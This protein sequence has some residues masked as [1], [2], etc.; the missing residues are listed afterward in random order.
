MKAMT[1]FISIALVTMAFGLVLAAC[2]GDDPTPT[3]PPTP[4]TAAP[5][6]AAPTT[7]AEATATPT[8]APTF[9]IPRT[10]ALLTLIDEAIAEGGT[11]NVLGG[12]IDEPGSLEEWSAEMTEEFGFDFKITFTAGGNMSQVAAQTAEEYIADRKSSTDLFIGTAPSISALTNAD[13]IEVVDWF[14]LAPWIHEG[15]VAPDGRSLAKS[16]QIKGIWYN[17]NLVK[18]NDIPVR[19]TDILNPK[20]KGLISTT[21]Y[22]AGFREAGGYFNRLD[23]MV[24]LLTDFRESGN[25]A[26]F[27]RCGETE[28][29]ASGE[30]AMFAFACSNGSLRELQ[31]KG[32]PVDYIVPED[33]AIITYVHVAIP[34]LSPHPAL[35]KLF[36]I[37][38]QTPEAQAINW[39]Y[40]L[41]DLHLIEGSRSAAE[42]EKKAPPGVTFA[43]RDP[44]YGR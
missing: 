18:G 26:G 15:S 30:F 35:A 39:K 20:W 13:A 23:E 4:T 19:T 11:L 38:W 27:M 29:I 14:A 9:K 42:I 34:K 3:P 44:R 16:T 37:Y 7:A 24:Q 10:P 22:V 12:S 32:A 25:L 41:D 36:S 31:A 43:G 28:R 6:T 40:Y 2:G 5:T 21:P 8:P 33:L 1:R 17:T